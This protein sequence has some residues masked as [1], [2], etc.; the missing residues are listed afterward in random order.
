MSKK[1]EKQKEN[2]LAEK[3]EKK[4]IKEKKPENKPEEKR[5]YEEEIEDLKRNKL[6]LLAQIE[7]QRKEFERQ[8]G[9]AYKYGGR[10]V[11]VRMLDFLVAL[12]GR[13]LKAMQ[14]DLKNASKSKPKDPEL[15]DKFKSHLTGM[16]IIKDNFKKSLEEQ[17][18]K[19]I[20]VEIG[21]TQANVRYHELIEEIEVD[22]FS[23]GAV[24]EVVEKGY[25]FHEEVLRRTKVKIA[26][27]P[28]VK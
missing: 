9:Y 23:E 16:E 11:I 7:N 6:L 2:I 28:K 25:F 10:L 26:K 18:V 1:E 15:I 5:K 21:K 20:E 3:L 4:E 8:V 27:R 12:E 22:N 13:A 19:E 24:V 14:D 17:G